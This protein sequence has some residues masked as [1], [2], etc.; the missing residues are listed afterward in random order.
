VPE[1]HPIEWLDQ[2]EFYARFEREYQPR[3]LSLTFEISFSS[4]REALANVVPREPVINP[5]EQDEPGPCSR[6]Y[7]QVDDVLF[8]LTHYDH[9]YWDQAL[10]A[11]RG[12]TAD[13]P[14]RWSVLE[15]LMRLP[16]PILRNT[17]SFFWHVTRAE[18]VQA[19]ATPP[20]GPASAVAFIDEHLITREAFV[21]ETREEA[22]A[23]CKVLM[24][25]GSKYDYYLADP[26]RCESTWSVLK[27]I[28][29]QPVSCV[30]R[31]PWRV[32]AEDVARTMSLQDDAIYSAQEE[33]GSRRRG[34]SFRRGK[35]VA[36]GDLSRA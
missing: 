19:P 29:T 27:S 24:R 35:A 34:M 28:P 32:S 3:G 7:G 31:Y 17:T 11:T 18:A 9:P 23:V 6:W 25:I 13:E 33:D 2:T 16:P 12:K 8:W 14:Y 20:R 22:Q 21:A 10:L 26:E 36:P 1:R 15:T 30:A 4:T 5:T